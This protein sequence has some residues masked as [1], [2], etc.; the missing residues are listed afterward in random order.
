[1]KIPEQLAV[2]GVHLELLDGVLDARLVREGSGEVAIGGILH[3]LVSGPEQ[4]AERQHG[5]LIF[6]F[7]RHFAKLVGEQARR[8]GGFVGGQLVDDLPKR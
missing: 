1:M 7:F 4:G 5:D 3:P 6:R 2:L 8:I